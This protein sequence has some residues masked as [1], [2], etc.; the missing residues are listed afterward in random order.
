M[1][2]RRKSVSRYKGMEIVKGRFQ[3]LRIEN[4]KDDIWSLF[5]EVYSS[6]WMSISTII[7][8]SEFSIAIGIN[9]IVK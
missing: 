7:L 5:L 9:T 4:C 1:T 6:C 2:I 3:E 8:L